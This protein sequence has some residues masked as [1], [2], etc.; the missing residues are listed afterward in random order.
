[1][2]KI[3]SVLIVATL[4]GC[5]SIV[6]VT[7]TNTSANSPTLM[8]QVTGNES[9]TPPPKPDPRIP[10]PPNTGLF[11]IGDYVVTTSDILRILGLAG[12]M[13]IIILMIRR[14]TRRDSQKKA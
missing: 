6:V 4:V 12:L 14:L 1:M 3:I 9:P 5:T 13:A 8:V 7:D 11:T 10:K 2:K